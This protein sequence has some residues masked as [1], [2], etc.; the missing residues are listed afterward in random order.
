MLPRSSQGLYLL[1]RL[2]DESHRFAISFHRQRR[3]TS[4]TASALDGV[5]GLG[6]TR[7]AAVLKHF[8]SVKRLRGATVEEIQQ[9]PG[10]GPALAES[11]HRHLT[12]GSSGGPEDR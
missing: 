3:S 10:L 4:M 6:P 11:I 2:R 1:Q 5:T 9:V 8:G 7:R 12:S